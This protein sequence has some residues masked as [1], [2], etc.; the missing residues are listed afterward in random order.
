MGGAEYSV[1]RYL[2]YRPNFTGRAFAGAPIA[3]WRN[4]LHR[5]PWTLDR[6]ADVSLYRMPWRNRLTD[7]GAKG[8]TRDLQHQVGVEPGMYRVPFRP[9]W[10]GF[11]SSEMG[12]HN[13]RP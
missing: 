5:L 12:F 13:F 7:R 2:S 6:Q 10:R 11:S 8:F 9:Q 3:E 1:G 4:R